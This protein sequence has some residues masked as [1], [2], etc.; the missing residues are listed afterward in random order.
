[1]AKALVAMKYLGM[2]FL[3][4]TQ[5]YLAGEQITSYVVG[6]PLCY[7]LVAGLDCKQRRAA[8]SSQEKQKCVIVLLLLSIFNFSRTLVSTL[9]FCMCIEKLAKIP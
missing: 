3:G 4:R 2:S 8:D 6:L 5:G 1:M 7:W 9:N